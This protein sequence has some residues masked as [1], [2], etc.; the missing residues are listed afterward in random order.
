MPDMSDDLGRKLDILIRL[1]AQQLVRDFE[2][3]KDKVLFLQK[4]GLGVRDIASVLGTSTNNVSVTIS[5]ARKAGE[6][7]TE[8]E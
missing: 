4:A 8:K 5:R 6:L 3:Q 7:P 2:S 1:Q